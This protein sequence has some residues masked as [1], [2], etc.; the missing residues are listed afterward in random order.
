MMK[1]SSHHHAAVVGG[2]SNSLL[3]RDSSATSERLF[4]GDTSRQLL[5]TTSL[6]VVDRF[7]SII[8][9]LPIASKF[10]NEQY[11]GIDI[12]DGK[13]NSSF[14]L[15]TEAQTSAATAGKRQRLNSGHSHRHLISIHNGHGLKWK[16]DAIESP[17]SRI[18]CF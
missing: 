8:E 16:Y 14:P 7:W 5:D 12:T 3:K 10:L 13:R 17:V 11:D 9:T 2:S 15:S 1:V 4:D 6:R 18:E